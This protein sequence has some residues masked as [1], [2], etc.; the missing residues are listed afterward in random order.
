VPSVS[1]LAIFRRD[2][3][4]GRLFLA[5][6]QLGASLGGVRTVVASPDRRHVYAA[7]TADGSLI[8]DALS[9]FAPRVACAPMPVTACRA[10]TVAGRAFVRLTDHPV[11]DDLNVL[12]W[13]WVGGSATT[14]ADFGAPQAST[15]FALC[16]Y[17]ASG[18][19]QPRLDALAPAGGTC[20]TKA[21]W[22]PSAKRI[23]YRDPV[24]TPDGLQRVTLKP[25]ADGRAA[26]IVKAADGTIPVP[27]LPLTPPVRVQMQA[28]NGEC[29]EA[30]YS[31]PLENDP[32]L[33]QARAD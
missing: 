2:T 23:Q 10:P 1:S 27:P 21:C 16:L 26:I 4:T 29:W 19:P 28:S 6:E 24:E 11:D 20:P 15:D 30:T 8:V 31:A 33:F 7:A 17:D 9:V 5:E 32:S 25:G 12:K 13:K 3:V 18:S 14:L 22:K